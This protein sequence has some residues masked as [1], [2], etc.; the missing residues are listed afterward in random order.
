MSKIIGIDL[1]TKNIKI[2]K[3]DKGIVLNDYNIL[4][5]DEKKKI[6]A[7]GTDAYEM[8]EKVPINLVVSYP[9]KNGVIAD[10]ENM[11]KLL[12]R[13][14]RKINCKGNALS[15]N[16]VFISIPSDISEVERKA[17]YDLMNSSDAS[18]KKT[19]IIEK[20]VAAAI[21]A[22]LD[23]LSP[24]GH[25]IVDIGGET[26][27]ISI[28]SLGGIVKTKLIN[29]GGNQ[30][31]ESIKNYIKKNFGIMIGTKSAEHIK[32]QLAMS[33]DEEKTVRVIGRDVITGLPKEIIVDSIL[34]NTS[35]NE[36]LYNIIDSIKAILEKTP[37]EITSDILESG[38]F[39]TG[40]CAKINKFDEL[41]NKETG[42]IV[43]VIDSPSEC[44]I[45]GLGKI[46][47]NPTKYESVIC[48]PQE[49]NYK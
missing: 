6:L 29:I 39:L 9:I 28:V 41:V 34:V 42:L 15:S 43:N 24:Q 10:Y 1:G 48:V 18:I 5:Q 16:T 31:D 38:I 12:N 19:Y 21:G 40:G 44:V 17:Y 47:E 20:S 37:P 35:I 26:T 46:I 8:I 30:M 45:R 4:A 7:I 32:N 33:F 2:Y 49:K 11:V 22:E 14:F 27:E 36:F 25:M 3:G 13:Y 23:V